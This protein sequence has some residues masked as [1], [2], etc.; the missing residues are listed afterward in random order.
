M[1]EERLKKRLSQIFVTAVLCFCLC[2]M[3]ARGNF[4]TIRVEDY[5]PYLKSFLG[6]VFLRPINLITEAVPL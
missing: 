2:S 6:S 3:V 1:K 5:F 4:S